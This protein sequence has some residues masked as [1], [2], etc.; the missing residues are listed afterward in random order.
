MFSFRTMYE[1]I[2]WS[3]WQRVLSY[4]I[5]KND[6]AD[7]MIRKSVSEKKLVVCDYNGHFRV[8]E[9]HIYGTY[10]GKTG[11]LTYQLWGESSSKELG[12]KRMHV[13]KMHNLTI[14]DK[15]FPGRRDVSDM[16]TKWDIV[17]M[18]VDE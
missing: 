12:W 14:L 5:P 9:I 15:T 7:W 4:V 8:V 13:S 16:H 6:P 11:V 10:K 3:I 18:L 17:Y 2:A 1:I